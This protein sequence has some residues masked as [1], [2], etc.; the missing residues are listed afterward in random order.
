MEI[1]DNYI[2]DKEIKTKVVICGDCSLARNGLTYYPGGHLDLFTKYE[3]L[4]KLDLCIITYY[5]NPKIDYT[6]FLTP[7]ETN[8]NIL[9]PSPE[10]AIVECIKFIDNVQ[11]DILIEALLNYKLFY[12]SYDKLYEVGKFFDVSK[13]D[14]DYWIG[15]AE[16]YQCEG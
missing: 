11:E 9:L 6:H 8:E 1:F 15:E 14:I 16:D 3:N 7:M 4:N 10:R 2:A 5:Y 13:N 12:N